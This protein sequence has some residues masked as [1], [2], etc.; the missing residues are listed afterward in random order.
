MILKEPYDFKLLKLLN[1]SNVV[2]GINKYIT[3]EYGYIRQKEKVSIKPFK[4]DYTILTPVMVYGVTDIEKDI[5][6]FAH[7]LINI[8][9]KWI[10]LDLRPVTKLTES[11][12]SFEIRNESEFLLLV[13]RFILTGMWYVGNTLPLYNLKFPH[14]VFAN[15]LSENISKKFGLDPGTQLQLKIIALVYYAKLFTDNWT[16]DDFT[17]LIIRLKEEVFLVKVIEEVYEKIDKL[18]SIDDFCSVCYTVTQN[19]RLKNFDTTVLINIVANN[20]V[21]LNAKELV[22]LSLEHPPTW[23]SMVY[24]A[25]TQ[26]SFS[27]NVIGT[28]AD[29]M[30]KRG[31]GDEFL[32]GLVYLTREYK[33]D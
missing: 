20:W 32:K 15:W 29:K 23:I 25:L 14:I 19:I 33:E 6:P 18:D 17:K 21:G 26:K 10:A 28:I 8:Q 1:N 27:R 4:N 9:G 30:N 7:P 3:L 13:Q 5:S 31:L 11:K 2:A 12:E 16:D 22:L 24:A